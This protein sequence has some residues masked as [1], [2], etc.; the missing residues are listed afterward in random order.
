M[1][2][3]LEDSMKTCLAIVLALATAAPLTGCAYGAIATTTDGKVVITRNDSFLFGALR[4]VF[5][6]KV[7]DAGVASCNA[8]DAP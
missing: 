2:F 5:V 6:C 1:T 3:P 4:K 7:T 8:A